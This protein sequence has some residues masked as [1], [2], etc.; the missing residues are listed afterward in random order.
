M[1]LRDAQILNA[2]KKAGPRGYYC[3]PQIQVHVGCEHGDSLLST[4]QSKDVPKPK[5]M[6][7]R[8]PRTKVADRETQHGRYLDSGPGAWDDRD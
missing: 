6:R 4:E 5:R 1:N 3:N 8:K 2:R 7:T